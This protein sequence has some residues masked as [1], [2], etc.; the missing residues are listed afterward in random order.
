MVYGMLD[1]IIDATALSIESLCLLATQLL[2]AK[3]ANHVSECYFETHF[4]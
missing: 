3:L 4:K 1:T 2:V